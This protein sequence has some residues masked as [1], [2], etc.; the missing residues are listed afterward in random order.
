[1]AS[2]FR[3]GAHTYF[4]VQYGYD[5]AA[6][7]DEIFDTVAEAGFQA[8]E[9][10][11]PM[12]GPADWKAR[13]DAA[14]RRT[15]LGLVGASHGQPMWDI[16]KRDE[17]IAAMEAHSDK[18]AQFGRVQCGVSCSG[19]RYADRTEA[20]NAQAVKV[21]AELGGMFRRKGVVLNYHTHGE[22]IQ[23]VRHVIDHVPADLLALGP[24]LD[25]LRVGGIDPEG[26][27]REHAGR[28][29]M[30][31]IRD[32]HVG[33]DRTEALGE[34]DAD[35]A[36]LKRALD[37]VGFAGEFVVELAVPPKRQPTRPP[38][39]LLKISRAHIRETMGM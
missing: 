24:D 2:S 28:I 15:G 29:S 32:Y 26:F 27:V 5:P 39:D 9:M 34:G 38:L 8:I 21:W 25:W 10:S 22:P 36:G 19:K 23:D 33:G 37:E 13:V 35:Y 14:L 17:I 20:E 1:M 6:R 11:T 31:H 12:L 30:L 3:V 16:S 18:L 4:F 7:L